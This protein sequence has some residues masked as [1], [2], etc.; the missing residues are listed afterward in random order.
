MKKSITIMTALMLSFGLLMGC[1]NGS[2]DDSS[3]SGTSSEANGNSSGSNGNSNS[4]GNNDNGDGGESNSGNEASEEYVDL[5]TITI[6]T[7]AELT[8]KT[9]LISSDTANGMYYYLVFKSN[10]K[11]DRINYYANTNTSTRQE[12]DYNYDASTGLI[13]KETKA[14]EYDARKVNGKIY[15]FSGS[16]LN[17]ETGTGLFTT[18]KSEK[19][20]ETEYSNT[21][22]SITINLTSNKSITVKEKGYSISLTQTAESTIKPWIAIVSKEGTFSSDKGVLT[23]NLTGNQKQVSNIETTMS[24]LEELM[25]TIDADTTGAYTIGNITET[26]TLIYDGTSLYHVNAETTLPGSN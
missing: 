13:S 24:G 10:S 20:D 3:S 14:I 9:F 26:A 15:L 2:S 8:G 6:P 19:H 7:V 11:A 16:H 17:R 25:N 1:A 22:S 18:F 5:S 23:C 12:N 4:D 21:F